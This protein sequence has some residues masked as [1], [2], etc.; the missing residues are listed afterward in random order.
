MLKA[1]LFDMDGTL[2]PM[3]AEAFTKAYMGSLAKKFAPHG[4]APEEMI[5]A[6]WRGVAAMVKNDGTSINE[7]VF[8]ATASARLGARVNADREKFDDFYRHDFDA[9]KAA[10]G[11][12]PA[13]GAAVKAL[14]A[15]GYTLV[16]ATNPVFPMTAQQKRLSWSGADEGDFA[17]ITSYENSHYCKPNPQYYAE[18]LG[19]IGHAPDECLMVGNDAREDLAAEQAGIRTFLTTRCLI[20]R[21][22]KDISQ[23]PQGDFAALL[24]YVNTL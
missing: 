4:Y 24:E 1:I 21:E 14:K 20:N 10:C 23:C 5:D 19:K 16:L 18:I 7:E 15:R 9:L 17:L 8:W 13:A 6:V 2:L 11:F 3:D 22:K 12:D